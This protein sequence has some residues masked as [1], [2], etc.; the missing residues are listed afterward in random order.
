MAGKKII[1][2]VI[3]IVLLAVVY[4]PGFSKLQELK[5]INR[6]LEKEIA[7]LKTENEELKTEVHSLE[8]DPIYVESV[9]REKFKKQK[10]GEIIYKTR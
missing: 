2:I 5:E 10:E 7:G 3:A 6:N 4:F 1:I 8:T 9:A